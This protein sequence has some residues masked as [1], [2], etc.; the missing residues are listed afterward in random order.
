MLSPPSPALLLFLF[1]SFFL[2]RSA[3]ELGELLPEVLATMVP[4]LESN[5]IGWKA[6]EP[7]EAS[8]L[9]AATAAAPGATAAAEISISLTRCSGS[10][11]DARV[12][13]L[14]GSGAVGPVSP[15]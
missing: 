8:A 13:P 5:L 3:Q 1:I 7:E 6:L 2:A 9:A 4:Q 11:S 14:G 12:S 10:D 15:R